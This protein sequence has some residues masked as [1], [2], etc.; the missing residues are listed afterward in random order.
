MQGTRLNNLTNASY[1]I[2]KHNYYILKYAPNLQIHPSHINAALQS[3][4]INILVYLYNKSNHNHFN[5]AFILARTN[6]LPLKSIKWLKNYFNDDFMTEI[7]CELVIP[8][9]F[10]AIKWICNNIQL[11]RSILPIALVFDRL[12]LIK[13]M[14][15]NINSTCDQALWY[16]SRT[17]NMHIIKWLHKHITNLCYKD[18]KFIAIAYNKHKVITWLR[19]VCI[20]YI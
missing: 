10:S 8:N 15:Y 9:N 2:N 14:Y 18:A 6:Q 12:T 7:A 13:W 20:Q 1:W 11:T 17:G 19:K 5:S 4:D 16:A 3:S